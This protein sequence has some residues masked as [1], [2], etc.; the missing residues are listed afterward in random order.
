M[1]FTFGL[2]ILF[3]PGFEDSYYTTL[4]DCNEIVNLTI[5]YGG[6]QISAISNNT[7]CTG[8]FFDFHCQIDNRFYRG[9]CCLDLSCTPPEILTITKILRDFSPVITVA[10]TVSI[11][12][13]IFNVGYYRFLPKP[14]PYKI[15]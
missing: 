9:L 4:R 1:N 3:E 7:Y 10:F 13:S 6:K 2:P 8:S 14:K 5:K 12:Y 11:L 15:D